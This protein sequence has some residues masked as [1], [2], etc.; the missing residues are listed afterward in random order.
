MI[1]Q[2]YM[3]KKAEKMF[4]EKTLEEYKPDRVTSPSYFYFKDSSIVPTNDKAE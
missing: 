2:K 1:A 4:F 3:G